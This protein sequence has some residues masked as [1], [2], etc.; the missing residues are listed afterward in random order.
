MRKQPMAC[1]SRTRLTG[2]TH[3]EMQRWQVQSSKRHHAIEQQTLSNS[4]LLDY[5]QRNRAYEIDAARNLLRLVVTQV[6]EKY[7]IRFFRSDL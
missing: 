5:L 2:Q 6:Q 4:Q 3:K 1:G 7:S